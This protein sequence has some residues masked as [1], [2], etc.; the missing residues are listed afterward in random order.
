MAIYGPAT[1]AKPTEIGRKRRFFTIE[2]ANKTLPFVKR[3]VADII[4]QHRKVG[5]IE[6]KCHIHRPS[7][8]R[9]EHENLCGQYR[10]QLEKLRDL[11]D[12]LAVVGCSLR[13][14]RRG[15]V[16]FPSMH[17]GRLVELCWRLGQDSIQFWHE[18]GEGFQS[19]REIDK[20]FT[21]QVTAS[22]PAVST[23]EAIG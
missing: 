14:M 4:K 2:H 18:V 20:E 13:D 12:E 6:E 5:A 7:V 10:V 3:V 22:D 8:S 21:A 23:F 1:K 11:T 15:I 19:R 17:R 16:D 9:E